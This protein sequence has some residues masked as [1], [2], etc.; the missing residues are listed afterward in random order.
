MQVDWR[1]HLQGL[2]GSQ[3]VVSLNSASVLK[4]LP[5]VELHIPAA[6]PQKGP[7]DLAIGE[8]LRKM[9]VGQRELS[10]VKNRLEKVRKK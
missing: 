2:K 5:L 9:E 4:E 10:K 3:G 1:Q 6:P 8:L 7:G